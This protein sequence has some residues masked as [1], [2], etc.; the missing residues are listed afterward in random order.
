MTKQK[1]KVKPDRDSTHLY[2]T[3]ATFV[4]RKQ[5]GLQKVKDHEID[6]KPL[7]FDLNI[8]S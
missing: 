2:K 1:V 4:T 5:D 6:S 3:Q 7:H 8:H